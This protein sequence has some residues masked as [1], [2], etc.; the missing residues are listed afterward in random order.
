[1]SARR[2]TS[3]SWQTLSGGRPVVARTLLGQTLL[4]L[5]GHL[6]LLLLLPLRNSREQRWQSRMHVC[7]CTGQLFHRHPLRYKQ[8]H[9]R[10]P[11]PG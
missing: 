5:L 3:W 4:L 11:R 9:R 6:P 1:M 10:H 7:G 2:M 8:H